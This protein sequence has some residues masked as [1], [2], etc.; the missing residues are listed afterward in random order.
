MKM[1]D[2]K[3]N[4]IA[5]RRTI[6]NRLVIALVVM[7]GIAGSFEFGKFWAVKDTFV[8]PHH[9]QWNGFCAFQGGDQPLC[10]CMEKEMVKDFGRN[11]AKSSNNDQTVMERALVTCRK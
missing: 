2:E 1:C 11:P 7:V 6:M 9:F 5:T 4:V 8:Q 3:E 10:A